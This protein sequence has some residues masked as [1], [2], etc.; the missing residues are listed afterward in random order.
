MR[1]TLYFIFIVTFAAALSGCNGEAPQEEP[2]EEVHDAELMG[3]LWTLEAIEVPGEPD[4]R[5]EATKVY[6]IQFSEEYNIE[7]QFDC[8]SYGG[9]YTLTEGN[10]MQVEIQFI[11]EMA[12]SESVKS[13]DDRLLGDYRAVHSYEIVGNRLQLHF[14]DSVLK[15]RNLE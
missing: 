6:S 13:I 14:D 11:T 8:N 15:F 1:K 3:T 9:A 4:I 7:G 12:C 5:P 10:S 2:Q